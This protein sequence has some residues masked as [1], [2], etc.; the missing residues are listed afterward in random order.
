LIPKEK[1]RAIFGGFRLRKKTRHRPVKGISYKCEGQNIL[2]LA[3]LLLGNPIGISYKCEGQNILILACLLLGNP[4]ERV[5]GSEYVAIGVAIAMVI[6]KN[7]VTQSCIT[8]LRVSH[9]T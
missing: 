4:I 7:H 3:C 6:E 8:R 9:I 2:I 5:F 1:I